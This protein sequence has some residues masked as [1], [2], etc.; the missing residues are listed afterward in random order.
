[1]KTNPNHHQQNY[2]KKTHTNSH[3][4]TKKTNKSKCLD[5][6]VTKKK[7][8]KRCILNFFTPNSRKMKSNYIPMLVFE[9]SKTFPHT[10]T[11]INFWMLNVIPGFLENKYKQTKINNFTSI[12]FPKYA[13]NPK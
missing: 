9:K 1:L 6:K 11:H 4:I 2:C 12:Q 10:P 3:K 13:L 7:P 5:E 8:T